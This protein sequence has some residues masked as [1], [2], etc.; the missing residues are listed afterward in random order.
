MRQLSGIVLVL[1]LLVVPQAA[2]AAGTAPHTIHHTTTYLSGAKL[3]APD[4]SEV[5]VSGYHNHVVISTETENTSS[6]YVVRGSATSDRLAADLGQFG[7]VDLTFEPHGKPRHRNVPHTPRGCDVSETVRRGVLQGTFSFHPRFAETA[8]DAT[9]INAKLVTY[10]L[11]CDPDQ[12]AGGG[13]HHHPRNK[14]VILNASNS[15]GEYGT[16]FEAVRILGQTSVQFNV[17]E[18]ERVDGV[19][20]YSSMLTRAPKAA[21]TYNLHRGSA[22]V[23]PPAPFSGSAQLAPADNG[24]PTWTGDLAV[25]LPDYGPTPLTGPAFQAGLERGVVVYATEGR[26]LRPLARSRIWT[27]LWR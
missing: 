10:E 1:S 25:T 9:E 21:F 22:T 26:W 12:I 17:T 20:I 6:T 15:Q 13:R 7:S 2:L 4:G 11:S 18:S 24:V 19:D 5:Y 3:S 23:T 8:I 27:G 16:R 14:A